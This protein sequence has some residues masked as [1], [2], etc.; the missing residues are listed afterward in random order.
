[1]PWRINVSCLVMR[2]SYAKPGLYS[3]QPGNRCFITKAHSVTATEMCAR[4]W[5]GRRIESIS[6]VWG[7]AELILFAN[8]FSAILCNGEGRSKQLLDSQQVWQHLFPARVC[9]HIPLN[10]DFDLTFEQVTPQ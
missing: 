7:I 3:A 2:R 5:N 1:M 10:T 4:C 9:Q 8:K 6:N